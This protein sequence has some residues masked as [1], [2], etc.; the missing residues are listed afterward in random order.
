MAPNLFILL[1]IVISS[2]LPAWAEPAIEPAAIPVTEEVTAVDE[3]EEDEPAGAVDEAAVKAAKQQSVLRE[4][5]A[6]LAWRLAEEIRFAQQVAG[7]EREI[8]DRRLDAVL[9]LEA[10]KRGGDLRSFIGWYDDY[11]YRLHEL[12][13]DVEREYGR[14]TAGG[15]INRELLKTYGQRLVQGHRE[16]DQ[17]LRETV[18]LFQREEAHLRQLIRHR[19]L[20]D[21]RHAQLVDQLSGVEN[22]LRDQQRGVHRQEDQREANSLRDL[23]SHLRQEMLVTPTVREDTLAHYEGI[24]I[25]AKAERE[26]L[27]L[28]LKEFQS[29]EALL[30][31]PEGE[32]RRFM[33]RLEGRFRQLIM[34]YEKEAADLKR[35]IDQLDEQRAAVVPFGSLRELDKARELWDN[36]L[37]QKRKFEEQ[38][39]RAKTQIGALEAE[40][41]QLQTLLRR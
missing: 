39:K 29:L 18:S 6:R 26:W 12:G 17:G 35:K 11:L 21:Q 32:G 14:L 38:I 23:I 15:D 8:V 24:I 41:S 5:A 4:Q 31:L 33:A 25:Q 16:L 19:Q 27:Q 36:Y 22:R 13:N 28:K 1:L 10:P 30:S 40:L 7:R 2:V 9:P 3:P 37:A 34:V 20:I